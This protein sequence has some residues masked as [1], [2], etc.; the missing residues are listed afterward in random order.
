MKNARRA[1]RDSDSGD[2]TDVM[3]KDVM[4]KR[5]E[6]S[7]QLRRLKGPVL[8]KWLLKASVLLWLLHIVFAGVILAADRNSLLL[9][10]WQ[11]V[12]VE[13][14]KQ[15]VLNLDERQHARCAVD[16]FAFQAE[17]AVQTLMLLALL[18]VAVRRNSAAHHGGTAKTRFA[19]IAAMWLMLAFAV[20][21]VGA[22]SVGES[23]SRDEHAVNVK[24]ATIRTL[25]QAMAV[26]WSLK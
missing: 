22:I 24:A 2:G 12:D 1:R 18:H 6:R 9:H 17:I 20:Y 13:T 4:D 11:N 7:L 19:V 23:F 25:M 16:G 26:V 10:F 21:L 14:K 8:V 3:D 15:Q 5:Y